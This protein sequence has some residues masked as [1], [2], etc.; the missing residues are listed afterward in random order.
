[1]WETKFVLSVLFPKAVSVS[2]VYVLN[3]DI[4]NLPLTNPDK[5]ILPTSTPLLLSNTK[6]SP[7]NVPP[8]TNVSVIPVTKPH[9]SKVV[10]LFVTKVTQPVLV[11]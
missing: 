5:S 3:N 4:S 6:F 10:P 1:M 2:P 11:S 8:V 9:T 7:V